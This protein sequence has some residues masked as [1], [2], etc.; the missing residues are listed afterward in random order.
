MSAFG[1]HL[2]I[3]LRLDR[4]PLDLHQAPI[5]ADDQASSGAAAC[6]QTFLHL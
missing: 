4:F 6:R 1:A 2:G 3:D 5:G